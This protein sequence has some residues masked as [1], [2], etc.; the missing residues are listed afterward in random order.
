MGEVFKYC[1]CLSVKVL[2]RHLEVEL[3]SRVYFHK[4]NY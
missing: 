2:N 3:T 4:G 1:S